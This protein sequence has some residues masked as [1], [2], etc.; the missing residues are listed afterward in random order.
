MRKYKKWYR[1]W[2]N[3]SASVSPEM[4]FMSDQLGGRGPHN[5]QILVLGFIGQNSLSPLFG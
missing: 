5:I 4:M 1:L 3:V 2:I